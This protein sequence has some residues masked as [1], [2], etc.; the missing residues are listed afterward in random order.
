ML[1]VVVVPRL[2]QLCEQLEELSVEALVS[3]GFLRSRD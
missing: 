1:R 2:S 3:V